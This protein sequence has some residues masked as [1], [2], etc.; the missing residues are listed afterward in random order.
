MEKCYKLHGYPPGFQKRNKSV[1]KANQV[2]SPISTPQENADSFQN[3]S[4]LAMQCQQLLN[5]L[6]A[7]AQQVSSSTHQVATLVTMRQPTPNSHTIP[8]MAGMHHVC[9]SSLSKPDLSHSVF[10]S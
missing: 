7:Q 5:M 2:S 8:T 4:S 9:L 3:F 6:N 10:S 1:A